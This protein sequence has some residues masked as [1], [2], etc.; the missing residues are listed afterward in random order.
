MT[1]LKNK[2]IIVTGGASGIGKKMSLIM[3]DQGAKIA[4]LDINQ[5][6]LK[7]MENEKN[8]FCF[9]CDVSNRDNIREVVSQVEKKLGDIHI[10]FN[11]AG[12]VIGKTLLE[13]TEEDIIKTY[14]I[15]TLALYWMTRAVLPSMLKRNEGHI[16]NIAS[17]AGIIGV[18]KLA[19]YSGSKFAAFAFDESLRMELRKQKSNIKTTVVCPYYINTGM[20][21]GVKT[22]FSFLLPILKEDYVANKIV[23]SIIKNKRRIVTPWIVYT[24]WPLRVLPVGVFDFVASF[25]GINS[26][27]DEFKTK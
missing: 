17:A 15:N 21:D 10:L 7:K 18:S 25:L 13:S 22:K 23:S 19:D 16:V 24:V 8:I 6:N 26:S 14:D 3:R 2:T 5:N 12:I 1:T 11:N 9:T 27:M 20:F 4:I